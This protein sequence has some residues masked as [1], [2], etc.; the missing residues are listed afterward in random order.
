[1]KKSSRRRKSATS[2]KYVD[3][4]KMK[5]SKNLEESRKMTSSKKIKPIARKNTRTM[6]KMASPKTEVAGSTSPI[7]FN[8][9]VR[10]TLV[11]GILQDI[12]G[13]FESKTDGLVEITYEDHNLKAHEFGFKLFVK[14][15]ADCKK[16][17][18]SE[19]TSAVVNT[20]NYAFPGGSEQYDI[21]IFTE[22]SKLEIEIVSNW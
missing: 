4:G 20:I 16:Q 18:F 9:E 22:D 13:Y 17:M 10:K 15:G 3:G 2:R 6:K 1:M 5:L 12:K 8:T 11:E 19:V 21:S 14:K 7:V